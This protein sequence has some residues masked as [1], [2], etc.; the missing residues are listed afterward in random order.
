L[1]RL[2]QAKEIDL[3]FSAGKIGGCDAMPSALQALMDGRM[4]ATVPDSQRRHH[5]RCVRGCIK[6]KDR[7]GTRKI[8]KH[9]VMDGPDLTTANAPGLLWMISIF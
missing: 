5:R 6:R 3:P 8:P 1:T 7:H 9:V 4:V 2:W